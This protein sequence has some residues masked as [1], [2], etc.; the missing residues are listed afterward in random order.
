MKRTTIILLNL[1]FS[2]FYS[3]ELFRRVKEVHQV[4][5]VAVLDQHFKDRIGNHVL[6]YLD[7]IYSLNAESKDGFLAEFNFNQLC[8]IVENEMDQTDEVKIICTDE[9]NLLHAGHLRKK[10][11]LSGNTDL[12]MIAF[13]D[14][15]KMK[16][17]LKDAGV[18]VPRFQFLKAEDSFVGLSNAIG[19]P[20]VIKPI[21]SCGSFGVYIIK[22]E[23]DYL[24]FY[25]ESENATTKFEVEEY[26]EGN[27]YHV[28]SCMQNNKITFI[29]ANEYSCPNHDYT[30]GKSLGSIPLDE[31]SDLAQSL[32]GFARRALIALG[33]K[34]LINHMEIFV[35]NDNELVF[36]EVSA[37]PPGGMINFIYPINHSINLMDMDFFMQSDLTV[38]LPKNEKKENA[39]WVMFPL[40]SG[41]INKFNTPSVKSRYELT[42]F[43]KVG[44]IVLPEECNSIVGKMAHA[45]FY[46]KDKN[47]LRQD[48]E[49]MR[50]F[51][52]VEM[53]E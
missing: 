19:L 12:D 47:I 21:D 36:L 44:D 8:E 25:N 31:R 23:A 22:N 30:K 35:T 10:Y 15:V 39:F 43:R 48:F 41:K 1:R 32:T 34:N 26:I 3:D 49:Y 18:R 37:R 42:S 29:S 28:D 52:L 38:E 46:H 14:K 50:T 24:K 9:F 13:R 51:N 17:I 27:L 45:V 33:S 16:D 20:F 2:D 6:P 7:K 40:M 4:R 53:A 11:N 5:F